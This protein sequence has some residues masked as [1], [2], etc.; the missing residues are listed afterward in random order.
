MEGAAM[1]ARLTVSVY[2]NVRK[3]IDFC[4]G[5]VRLKSALKLLTRIESGVELVTSCKNNLRIRAPPKTAC[6]IT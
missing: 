5:E 3:R 6:V 2:L 1:A 4:K